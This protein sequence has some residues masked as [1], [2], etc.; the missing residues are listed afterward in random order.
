MA[1]AVIITHPDVTIDPSV[2][3]PDWPLSSRGQARMRA[4]LAQ[5]WVPTLRAVH[6]ST[7]RK[8]TDA[9]GILAAHLTLPFTTHANLGENDRSATGYLPREEF[10][11]TA[12]AFFA[13][14]DHSISGW[15]TARAAQRRIVTAV[16][17]ILAATPRD[18]DI[19]LI[20]HGAVAT[21]L[22]CALENLPI[23]R[24]HDQPPGTGG[25]YYAIDIATRL[26]RHGW[27][28]IDAE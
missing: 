10:E 20:T 1:V 27:I 3:V 19:A 5:P 13:N 21:L 22:F 26:T 14:P 2:P 9:A 16:N 28:P 7:E 4:A 6:S 8:A 25:F 12:D 23:S 24:T 17:A 15:E 18:H 11:A